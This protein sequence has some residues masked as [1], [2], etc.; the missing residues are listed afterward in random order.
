MTIAKIISTAIYKGRLIVKVLGLGKSDVKTVYQ[1]LP[2]GIDCNP[3]KNYRAIYA[4]TTVKGEKVLIGVVN[5]DILTEAGELRLHSE[6]SNGGEAIYLHLKSN[7]NFEINGNSDNLVRYLKLNEG[8]SDMVTKIN[9]EL[10]KIQLAIAGIGGAYTK[11]NVSVDISD[12]KINE[13]L[14]N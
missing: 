12:A 3:T 10:G 5:N 7:G 11:T 14:T 2:F 13:L 8:L 1:I 4:D 9:T 6:N